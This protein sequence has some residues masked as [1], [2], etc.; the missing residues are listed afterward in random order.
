METYKEKHLWGYINVV[1]G[2]LQEGALWGGL[3]TGKGHRGGF[4]LLPDLGGGY[5]AVLFVIILILYN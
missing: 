4:V 3:G 5:T 2:C 1:P